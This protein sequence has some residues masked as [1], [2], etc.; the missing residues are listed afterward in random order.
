MRMSNVQ[1]GVSNA[2]VWTVGRGNPPGSWYDSRALL[3]WDPD[4]GALLR[5]PAWFAQRRSVLKPDFGPK[6]RNPDEATHGATAAPRT[7]ARRAHD[8]KAPHI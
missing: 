3:S 7:D 5:S 8:L 1:Q 4:Y 2:Q 6:V